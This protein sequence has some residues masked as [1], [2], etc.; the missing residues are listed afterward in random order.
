MKKLSGIF[1]HAPDFDC[2][3]LGNL[4]LDS[5]SGAVINKMI[6]DESNI[7]TSRLTELIC[8]RIKYQVDT[9]LTGGRYPSGVFN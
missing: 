6:T 7:Y 5:F 9:R 8:V 3:M 1:F 2:F 4:T